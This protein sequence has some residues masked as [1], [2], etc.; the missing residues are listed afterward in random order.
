MS[1]SP[2]GIPKFQLAQIKSLTT[3]FVGKSVLE[4]INDVDAHVA[5]AAAAK[6]DHP[7]VNVELATLIGERIKSA[8]GYWSELNETQQFWMLGA[9]A[10][11][12][13]CDDEE[14]DFRS[15]IGFEDDA[16]IFNACVRF[17]DHEE[18]VIN[19]EDF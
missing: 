3:D 6:A 16:E 19:K 15:P 11:F 10:Y 4:L 13:A 12:A 1:E 9:V 18:L 2:P 17:A 7:M 5:L 8:L 14:D